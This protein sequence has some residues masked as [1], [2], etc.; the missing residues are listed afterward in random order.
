MS[1]KVTLDNLGDA[2][3]QLLDE[4]GDDVSSNMDKITK[5]VGKKGVQALKSES[6]AKFGT[7]RTRSK[8]YANTWTSTTETSRLYTTVTIHNSQAWQPH[9]LENGHAKV[10][11]G[12][13]Q[14]RE[15]IRPIEEEIIRDY[16]REL[17]DKL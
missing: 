13:V 7:S 1:K 16:E 17:E 15:H 10:G 2:I 9:L 4:Y 5:E 8:K 11:G 14:G 6:K 12:R 3:K